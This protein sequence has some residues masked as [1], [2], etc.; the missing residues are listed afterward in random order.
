M[1]FCPPSGAAR[2]IENRCGTIARCKGNDAKRSEI[3]WR[4]GR[5][6][7][8]DC[9]RNRSLALICHFARMATTAMES[10]KG[11][12]R[13]GA[14]WRVGTQHQVAATHTH[15]YTHTHAYSRKKLLFFLTR[16]KKLQFFYKNFQFFSSVFFASFCFFFVFCFCV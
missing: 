5:G 2:C 3:E 15:P 16:C 1:Q 11:G 14:A 4:R 7:G 9:N 6:R 13:R 10:S 8:R 12:E